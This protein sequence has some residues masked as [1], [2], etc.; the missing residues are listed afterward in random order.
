MPRLPRR[1]ERRQT[2]LHVVA[3]PNVVR[4]RKTLPANSKRL[5]AY[6]FPQP[7]PPRF[8]FALFLSSRAR[9]IL[10]NRCAKAAEKP[11]PNPM[12]KRCGKGAENLRIHLRNSCDKAVNMQWETAGNA[13]DSLWN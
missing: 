5:T 4:R 11:A 10:R 3:R 1:I 9:Q 7:L 12:C 6:A 13:V 8:S 2:F